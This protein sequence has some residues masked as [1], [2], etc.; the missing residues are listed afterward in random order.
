MY[1]CKFK[2]GDYVKVTDSRKCY[3]NKQ[4]WAT[5]QN[6]I[7]FVKGSSVSENAIGVVSATGR[8]ANGVNLLGITNNGQS[9]IVREEDVIKLPGLPDNKVTAGSP[10]W[11][12]GIRQNTKI[13]VSRDL[14]TFKAGTNLFLKSDDKST[15]PLFGDGVSFMYVRLNHLE[16]ENKKIDDCEDLLGKKFTKGGCCVYLFTELNDSKENLKIEWDFGIFEYLPVDYCRERLKK[17]SWKL[18]KTRKDKNFNVYVPEPKHDIIYNLC[19]SGYVIKKED[20]VEWDENQNINRPTESE[21]TMKIEDNKIA[22]TVSKAA[23]AE[24]N[25]VTMYGKQVNADDENELFHI[26]SRIEKD[27]HELK[28]INKTAKSSRVSGRISA[29]GTARSKVVAMIDALPSE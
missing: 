6:L 29:L 14:P 19:N 9:Y 15:Y 8:H 13:T 10:S 22:V 2:I 12:A 5:E 3:L 25:I 16:L 21:K 7:N 1:K 11:E 4:R 27:Q 17:G 24:T 28:E 26:L 20:F 18:L 23:Y